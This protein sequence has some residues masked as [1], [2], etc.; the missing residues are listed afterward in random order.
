MIVHFV[1]KTVC[2]PDFCLACD[3]VAKARH[4]YYRFWVQIVRYFLPLK[5]F[6]GL[7]VRTM[8]PNKKFEDFSKLWANFYIA[9]FRHI[10]RC[11]KENNVLSCIYL[12]IKSLYYDELHV[13]LSDIVIFLNLQRKFALAA[14]KITKHHVI[15]K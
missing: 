1:E 14:I 15:V 11:F 2:K 9:Y 6:K 7:G 3:E 8:Y 13:V 12:T 4:R 10:Q 5:Q